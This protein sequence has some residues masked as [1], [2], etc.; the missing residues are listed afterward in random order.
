VA[1]E[2]ASAVPVS[3]R[4]LGT[5]ELGQILDNTS[6]VVFV[7]D[8][9][10]RYLF[11]NRQFLELFDLSETGI[12][13]RVDTDWLAPEVAAA[14]RGNDDAVL[15]G[16]RELEFEETLTLAD[17]AHTYLARKFPLFDDAGRA[18]AVCGIAT[19]ITRR[20]MTED[21]LRSIALGVS[22]AV[23]DE[24]HRAIVTALAG[25]LAVD[26]AF[27]ATRTPA[28]EL[29]T[30]AVWDRESQWASLSYAIAETPCELVLAEGF[31][32]FSGDLLQRFPGDTMLSEGA[33][34]S[35]A[36]YPLVG[37]DGVALGVLSVLRRTALPDSD[38]VRSM[39]HIFSVRASAELE[40]ERAERGR[41]ISEESYRNIFEA[42]ED[43]IFVRDI[44]TGAFVDVNPKA[45]ELTGYGYHELLAADVGVLSSGEDPYTAARAGEW[46]AR[47]RQHPQ[48][49]EWHRRNKDGS[50]HWDEVTLKRAK[51]AGIDRILAFTREITERKARE[52]ARLRLE[53][54]L[55]QAQ[56]MEAIGHLTGGI[57]HDFN[58]ILTGVT[59]YLG[60]AADELEGRGERR[61]ER[62][63]AAAQESADRARDL[64]GQMLTFSRGERG[65]P[66]SLH[67]PAHLA[68]SERLLQST[69][70][71]AIV[72]R[73]RTESGTPAI[74]ADPVQLDQ[75]L[76]NLCINARDAIGDVG[77]VEVSARA[78]DGHDMVCSSCRQ[79]VR[80][81]LVEL[82]VSDTGP[83]V[84]PALLQRLF[85]PFFT[86]K[87]T[88]RGSG[89]GLAIVHGI[90]HE[91]GGHVVVENR[92]PHGAAFRVL[93][94]AA[95]PGRHPNFHAPDMAAPPAVPGQDAPL[96]GHA[97][98]V[99]DEAA[100]RGFMEELLKRQ[101]LAVTA[102]ADPRAARDALSAGQRFDL[103][104]FDQAMP[105][106][107]GL[108]LA[109]ELHG[110]RAGLP[111]ILYT[112]YVG[113]LA[114]VDLEAM[115]VHALLRKPIDVAHFRQLLAKLLSSP[116]SAYAR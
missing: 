106:L 85:E 53:D 60:L 42:S 33:Y 24:V 32:F 87:D 64:I 96:H 10:G 111:V 104:I 71:A 113:D 38:L 88:G 89:M 7:K 69:M 74:V 6:A 70:P 100:V 110:W 9:G 46:L 84:P 28:G 30:L 86:T 41:H 75:V 19:D 1:Q 77:T 115:G 58:N 98:L 101:G 31:Q 79:P 23:G 12:L 20:K 22:A 105:H 39:L 27:I 47:A 49:V 56:K 72:L 61:A 5:P 83:G 52:Q 4:A 54:Q 91:Y 102:F 8:R 108:D 65:A 35:Y 107:T 26:L 13:G 44:D 34:C 95:E 11:V 18:W 37:S 99:E 116:P 93:L 51:I 66:R 40:R 97:L 103:A 73:I 50:L 112:G 62:Y 82:C 29:R 21:A 67:P 78:I 43:A 81:R 25:V 55:R 3:A 63:L 59:G 57:A 114:G 90:V 80:G 48:R 109:R 14:L 92:L 45:C 36:G 16:G 76:M 2:T 17:G 94:P 15:V 68:A